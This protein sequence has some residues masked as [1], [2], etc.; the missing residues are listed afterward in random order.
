VLASGLA[1]ALALS[2]HADPAGWRLQKE[3]SAPGRCAAFLTD[4]QPA[5]LGLAQAGTQSFLLLKAQDLP[6]G[7]AVHPLLAA[8]DDGAPLKLQAVGGGGTYVMQM[9]PALAALIGRGGRLILVSEGKSFAFDLKGG[10]AAMDQVARC[11]GQASF[12]QTS[13][14]PPSPAAGDWTLSDASVGTDWCVMRRRGEQVDTVLM[15]NR[16]GRLILGAGKPSWSESADSSAEATL[17]VDGGPPRA[18]KVSLLQNL[19]LTLVQD[20]AL[21]RQLRGASKIS[22]SLPQGDFHADVAGLGPAV[23]ALR[24]CMRQRHPDGYAPPARK[25]RGRRAAR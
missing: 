24:V 6:Q 3:P 18:V 12:V 11:A 13:A 20:G 8:L 9:T 16:E 5:A 14:P 23:D 15:L 7:Q 22:W 19:A 1:L 21:S 10:R 25:R 2:A 17:A 4:A